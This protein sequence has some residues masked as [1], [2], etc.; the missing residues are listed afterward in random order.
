MATVCSCL[1]TFHM[2]NSTF[3]D[4]YCHSHSWE[5]QCFSRQ[6]VPQPKTNSNRMAAQQTSISSCLHLLFLPQVDPFATR[7]NRQLPLFVSPYPDKS[8]WAV[9]ALALDWTGRWLYAFPPSQLI[10]AVLQQMVRQPCHVLLIAP[11]RPWSAWFPQLLHLL[12][13]IPIFLNHHQDLLVQKKWSHT[14]P[15]FQSLHAWHLCSLQLATP[16]LVRTWRKELLSHREALPELCTRAKF[17]FFRNGSPS[18]G[19][20]GSRL[21]YP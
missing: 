15:L 6:P 17:R 16:P 13:E 11:A 21:L 3:S 7:L 18:M 8:A 19:L 20:L 5:A 9:D 12:W 2:G 1:E 4:T 14:C 10:P